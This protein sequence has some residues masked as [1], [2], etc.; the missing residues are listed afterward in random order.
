M[1]EKTLEIIT[2]AAGLTRISVSEAIKRLTL[3]DQNTAI[4]C[5]YMKSPNDAGLLEETPFPPD[6]GHTNLI[7]TAVI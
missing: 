2:A 3:I 1:A 6:T 4:Y 5:F 7:I